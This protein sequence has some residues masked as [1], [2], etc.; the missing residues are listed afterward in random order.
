MTSFLNH[1]PPVER[2]AVE[3]ALQGTMEERDEEDLLDLF[4]RMGSHFIPPKNSMQ[5]AIETV[6]HKAV[7]Q[8][9][10]YIAD[11]LSTPMALVQQKLSDKE[12]VLSLC[13]SKKLSETTKMVLSQREQATF[14]HLQRY[15]KNAENILRFCTGSSVICVD[16]MMV[17]FNAETGLNRRPV[18]HTCCCP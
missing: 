2:S 14:N 5:P 12:S 15:V 6:A 4:T 9:P 13:E 16:K 18:A 3:K 11:C 10:E 7:L 1:L 17:C 8:E